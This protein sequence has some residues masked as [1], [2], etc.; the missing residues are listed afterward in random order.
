[1]PLS[2]AR[3][4]ILSQQRRDDKRQTYDKPKSLF[5]RDAIVVGG[6]NPYPKPLAVQPILPDVLFN[7]ASIY[8]SGN[9]VIETP[10]LDADGNVIP[11][12]E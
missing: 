3:M 9:I 4:K 11:G 7:G 2:K 6:Y 12:V 10:E 8:E 1:M 5:H